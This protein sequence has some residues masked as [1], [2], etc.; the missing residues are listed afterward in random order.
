SF[1]DRGDYG[2]GDVI[3]ELAGRVIVQEKQRLA[4]LD[5]EIVGAH[6]DEVDA[7]AVVPPGF[8]RELELGPDPVVGRDQ[9]RIAVAGRLEVEKTAKTAQLGVRARP[10][11]RARQGA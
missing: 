11:S 6:R 5:D 4:A 7:N 2:R 10:G 8:D 3:V 9:Q 1:G